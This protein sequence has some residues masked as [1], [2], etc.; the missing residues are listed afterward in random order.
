[1]SHPTTGGSTPT[2]GTVTITKALPAQTWL[3]IPH[4]DNSSDDNP[5]RFDSRRRPQICTLD[6]VPATDDRD[7]LAPQHQGSDDRHA[8]YLL[9]RHPS[10]SH[11]LP[12]SKPGHSDRT[13]QAQGGAREDCSVQ[14]HPWWTRP[15][16]V[17]TLQ[18]NTVHLFTAP[19][20]IGDTT[21]ETLKT[22]ADI[23]LRNPRLIDS[24]APCTLRSHGSQL[25]DF[26]PSR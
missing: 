1:M 15:S 10:L 6:A 12:P 13:L 8:L 24:R 23:R 18:D 11:S 5:H 4:L 19:P 16:K 25:H 21:A 20:T 22:R 17:V 14:G 7:L 26:L 9:E 3:K 2:T